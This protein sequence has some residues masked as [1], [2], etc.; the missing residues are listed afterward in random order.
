MPY[1]TQRDRTPS[2]L[3][4]QRAP[5]P[6]PPLNV[7][8]TSGFEPGVFD[9]CWDDPA[10]LAANARF[11]L[12]GVNIYRSFDS[13]YG[14]FE[15]LTELPIGSKFWRDRTD[16]ELVV[17][18]DVSDRFILF[19]AS[20]SGQDA[21]RYVFQTMNKPIVKADSQ[22]VFADY[23][24]D[25]RVYVD[26]VEAQVL[27]VY[28]Q[29]GEVEINAIFYPNVATQSLTEPVTPQLNSRVT[30][31][32]RRQRSLLRTDL[33]Q[34]IFYRVTCVGVPSDLDPSAVQSQDLMETP[35]ESA[36][37][38]HSFAVEKLDYIW[39]EA[40]RRNRWILEQGGER[41]RAFMRKNV[42]ILCRCI[43]DFHHKQP[44]NDCLFCYGTGYEGGYEGPYDVIVAP[45]DGERR[46]AQKDIGR[47]VEHT[48]EVWTGPA[49][50]FSQRDFIV[51]LNGDRYSVGPVRNPSARGMWLQQHFTLGQFDSND[52]RAKV[53]MRSPVQ[54]PAVQIKPTGPEYEA[55][56]EVTG[57]P[58]IP[59][60]RE[61]QGRTPVWEN[62]TY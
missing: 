3:E 60:E 12:H 58:N 36:T 54:F 10:E 11:R 29:T 5:W 7:F 31:T 50:V 48:Y 28:G 23:P 19:G 55:E 34:R 57:K 33:A 52:I 17:D 35:L 32:Y 51:K 1:A 25:V 21:P 40:I 44:Q 59:D 46:I 45:D 47:T 14:P 37:A 24:G 62:I 8:L 38:V 2:P 18:E 49:P 16:N 22:G 13:E 53:P 41:V 56:A 20:A 15:R 6:A 27:R 30:C 39:R 26:D 61:L 4:V 42:G 43:P 9:I